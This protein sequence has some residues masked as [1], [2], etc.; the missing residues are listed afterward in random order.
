MMFGNHR[1]TWFIT[2]AN[3]FFFLYLVINEIHHCWQVK[4]TFVFDN[5]RDTSQLPVNVILNS[6]VMSCVF[7]P[8]SSATAIGRIYH[9]SHFSTTAPLSYSFYVI[10]QCLVCWVCSRDLHFT[11]EKFIEWSS[12]RGPKPCILLPAK[13]LRVCVLPNPC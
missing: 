6:V 9:I 12:K 11:K 13:P 5:H 1:D 2:V 4:V 8:L 7:S 3:L 10:D